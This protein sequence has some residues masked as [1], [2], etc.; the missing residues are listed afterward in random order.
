MHA[1]FHLGHNVH[2][3]ILRKVKQVIYIMYL[4]CMID[5]IILAQAVFQIFVDNIALIYEIP[6]SEK[7]NNPVKYL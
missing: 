7:G 1:K 4:N 3:R 6:K 2:A 5:A